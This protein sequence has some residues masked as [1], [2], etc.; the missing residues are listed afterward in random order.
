MDEDQ[1]LGPG[2]YELEFT[3]G[4]FKVINLTHIVSDSLGRPV[5]LVDENDRYYNGQNIISFKRKVNSHG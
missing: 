2:V 3:T 5:F 1:I 4:K